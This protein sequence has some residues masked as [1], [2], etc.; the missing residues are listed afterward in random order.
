MA[1]QVATKW[2]SSVDI[3]AA[4]CLHKANFGIGGLMVYTGANSSLRKRSQ[5]RLQL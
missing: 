1:S 3:S 4:A 2:V 5:P